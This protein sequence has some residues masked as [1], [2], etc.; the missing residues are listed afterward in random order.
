MAWIFLLI[1]GLF[2]IVWAYAMKL[3]DGFTRPV[4]SAVTIAAMIVSFALLSLAMRT[5][6]LGTAYAIWTGIGA[7]GAFVASRRRRNPIGWLLWA[8]GFMLLV[9][10]AAEGYALR[11]ELV[12]PLPGAT[13]F[14][15][16]AHVIG[17]PILF[18]PF[19]AIFLLFPTGRLKS[20]RWRWVVRSAVV[21]GGLMAAVF[22][23]HPGE[24]RSM[25]LHQ[26][27]LGVEAVGSVWSVAEVPVALI[28]LGTLLAAAG[29]PFMRLRRAT[30]VER[31]QIRWLTAA[32][33]FLGIAIGIAPLLWT[34][35]VPAPEWVW[36]VL[37]ALAASFLPAAIGIAI[38]R[39]RLY[40]IDVVINRTL[41]YGLLT[42]ILAASYL[43]LV[44]LMQFVL[45]PLTP[46]SDLSIV[47]STLAV[48]ALFRPLRARLQTFIDRRFYRQ[49]Y[50]AAATLD[51]FS[52]R[53]R[54]QVDL[55]SL[56]SE[57]VGVVGT[58]MQPAH[59][60]LWLRSREKAR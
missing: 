36:P 25:P 3:S 24:L 35:V 48:A 45:Q 47:I 11:S 46:Q 16:I 21:S 59:A 4:A 34:E 50:D 40:D 42:G 1:A 29:S 18:A 56:R 39:Y 57:V 58:T 5:L 52:A 23:L 7:L 9:A 6:P 19:I 10:I 38:L 14:G 37:F 49:R 54:D 27:P 28:F 32:A 44:A 41:V 60:S 8:Q 20:P 13:G 12:A 15:L 31:Q 43:G 51:R 17:G 33:G 30:G 26:N 22:L 55:E 53:L 2:E